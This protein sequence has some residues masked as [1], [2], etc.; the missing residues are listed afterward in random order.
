LQ[1]TTQGIYNGISAFVTHFER[2]R[3]FTTK[4]WKLIYQN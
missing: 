4:K 1:K 2:S 3:G